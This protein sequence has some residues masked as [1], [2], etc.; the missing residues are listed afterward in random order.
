[1]PLYNYLIPK[2]DFKRKFNH[3]QDT[4]HFLGLRF[5]TLAGRRAD[6][7]VL[8]VMW[9]VS[10]LQPTFLLSEV[11]RQHKADPTRPSLLIVILRILCYHI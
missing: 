9:C 2:L 6:A 10:S 8:E 1:M 3:R 11:F 5:G 4:A 7:L